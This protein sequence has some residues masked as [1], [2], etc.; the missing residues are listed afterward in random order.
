MLAAIYSAVFGSA[1]Q[2]LSAPCPSGNCTWPLTPSLGACGECV[3]STYTRKDCVD[4]LG[5]PSAPYCTYTF[6][7]GAHVS[8]FDMQNYTLGSDNGDAGAAGFFGIPSEEVQPGSH[9]ASKSRAYF[10]SF[11]LFG[12]PYGSET[13]HKLSMTAIERAL[14]MCVQVY[15]TSVN[16]TIQSDEIVAT[17]TD[18][19]MKQDEYTFSPLPFSVDQGV[20]A[21]Y[22][23]SN[24][25]LLA[26]TY[27]MDEVLNG[28]A[29][30]AV[31]GMSA[32][33]AIIQGVWK[34]FSDPETWIFNIA[35]SMSNVIRANGTS[36]PQYDGDVYELGIRIRWKW[37]ILPAALVGAV[38]AAFGGCDVKDG[39]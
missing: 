7:T 15:N 5:I 30:V 9:F 23:V 20:A 39:V 24:K 3:S 25:S 21:S 26:L 38:F 18:Y 27:A 6:P 16:S 19:S 36:R 11:Y 22:T 31:D 37:L 34:G 32:S 10:S 35:T 14:W 33:S 4:I 8:T 2:P 17:Y 28:T 12:V 13:S 1:S 29:Y